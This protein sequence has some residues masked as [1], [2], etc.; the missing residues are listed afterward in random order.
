MLYFQPITRPL[1]LNVANQPHRHEPTPPSNTGADNASIPPDVSIHMNVI[2]QCI[3]RRFMIMS[4][5]VHIMELLISPIF[6][7]RASQHYSR[8]NHEYLTRSETCSYP[9]VVWA[10]SMVSRLPFLIALETLITHDAVRNGWIIRQ[11]MINWYI[12]Y[13]IFLS[14]QI[15]WCGIGAVWLGISSP[16]R[17]RDA[18]IFFWN[19]ILIC[20]NFSTLCL[21]WGFTMCYV[22]CVDRSMLNEDR[23]H[24]PTTTSLDSTASIRFVNRPELQSV[25]I[26]EASDQKN[27][28]TLPPQ[29]SSY[30]KCCICTET[31]FAS[32]EDKSVVQTPCNHRYH[33]ICLRR[34]CQE[35]MQCPMCKRPLRWPL[36]L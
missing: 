31:F 8:D 12:G 3:L 1:S 11:S 36:L 23:S 20:I 25:H 2:D 33:E 21:P 35:K 30:E 34:W 26:D 13:K 5:F 9:L 14:V 29:N 18:L 27:I 32:R 16:C 24:L 7:M 15:I 22:L 28:S 4:L 19:L 6:V 17:N 10:I